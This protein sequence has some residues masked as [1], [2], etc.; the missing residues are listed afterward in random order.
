MSS[1]SQTTEQKFNVPKDVVLEALKVVLPAIG[2]HPAKI[3]MYIGR[4]EA[5]AGLSAFSWGEKISISV[6]EI[7]PGSSVVK[8]E[9]S[10]KV[11][12]NIPGNH[13]HSKNFNNIIFSLSEYLQ[14]GERG[15][16]KSNRALL[17][18]QLSRKEGA[19]SGFTSFL[20]ICLVVGIVSF[21]L[22]S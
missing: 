17:D 15:E 12:V 7:D 5:S 22:F 11:A 14:K 4:I 19:G 6:D 3:D 18:E 20:W 8:I 21:F 10:L 2:I 1:G 13:R 16:L 9:S